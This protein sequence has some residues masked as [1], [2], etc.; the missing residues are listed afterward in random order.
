MGVLCRKTPSYTKHCSV[1][2]DF[3]RQFRQII[4]DETMC[5]LTEDYV[6][7]FHSLADT[8]AVPTQEYTKQLER[9]GISPAKIR[10]FRRG[11]DPLVF[12]PVA[13]SEYLARTLGIVD[14]IT[15]LHSGRV[16]KEKNLD[17]LATVYES[18]IKKY[19]KVNLVFAGNGPYFDEYRKK[20]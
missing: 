5:Q 13:S 17:F 6:N 14:G 20:E 11:I 19:P 18:L 4:G 10:K 16:S 1:H 9:H 12:A 2:T 7:W 15:L 8:V 3:T